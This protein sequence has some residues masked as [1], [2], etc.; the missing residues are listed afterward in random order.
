LKIVLAILVTASTA[1]ANGPEA[2]ILEQ[3]QCQKNPEI[4]PILLSLENSS[5]I[6]SSEL[7]GI[8]SISCFKIHGGIDVLGLRFESVCGFEENQNV[9]DLRPDL[10]WRGPGTAPEHFI[11]F[12][13]TAT[14]AHALDWYL[15]NI[16]NKYQNLA[17]RT[18]GTLLDDP[19]EIRCSSRMPFYP[20]DN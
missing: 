19:V 6:E 3:L 16:G 10:L 2:L 8:D 18:E 1:S 7:E 12:G 9:R 20:T 13:T 17:I 14:P 4:L 15:A 5:Q 11:S